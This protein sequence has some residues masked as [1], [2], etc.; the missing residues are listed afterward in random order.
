MERSTE[1]CPKCGA[2]IYAYDTLGSCDG[3]VAEHE[4]GGRHCLRRQLDKAQAACAAAH[5]VE[6]PDC[7]GCGYWWSS[8][9]AGQG[10]AEKIAC[11][12]CGGHEDSAGTGYVISFGDTPNHGQ[13]ILD[14]LAAKTAECERLREVIEAL[15]L[16]YKMPARNADA[17]LAGLAAI[18][19]ENPGK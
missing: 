3:I 9:D 2:N 13:P 4:R 14:Q 5:L 16:V 18:E 10:G 12:T 11:P 19:K 8:V 17:I 1:K 15:I 7:E 6:C